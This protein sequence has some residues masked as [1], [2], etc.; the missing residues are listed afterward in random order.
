MRERNRETS[1]RSP[2]PTDRLLPVRLYTTTLVYIIYYITR[3]VSGSAETSGSVRVCVVVIVYI[4]FLFFLLLL[5]LFCSSSSSSSRRTVAHNN[6][7][8]IS[9]EKLH[10]SLRCFHFR[11]RAVAADVAVALM[12][13]AR[14]FRGVPGLR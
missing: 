13:S 1:G 3:A 10:F 7:N 9:T 5:F 4:I 2:T 6:I 8:S 11:T 12:S 14:W